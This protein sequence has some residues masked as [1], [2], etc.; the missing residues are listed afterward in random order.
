[1][2]EFK[3]ALNY[4]TDNIDQRR[5]HLLKSQV[6]QLT[7]QNKILT[8]T[9]ANQSK[10]VRETERIL[11]YLDEAVMLSSKKAELIYQKRREKLL[12]AKR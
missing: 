4:K 3:Q 2:N 8:E 12:E 10:L 9:V 7:R 1:M 5:Y 6:I 11:H